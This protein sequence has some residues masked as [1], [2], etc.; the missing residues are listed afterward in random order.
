MSDPG[1]KR[2]D[3]NED[4]ASES[5]PI[6]GIPSTRRDVT[7]IPA[8]LGDIFGDLDAGVEVG[9]E[10]ALNRIL[11]LIA[12]LVEFGIGTMVRGYSNHL[13][14]SF[15]FNA[16]TGDVV[17][18]DVIDDLNAEQVPEQIIVVPTV[19][20]QVEFD[21]N[22]DPNTPSILANS[23]LSSP[24]RVRKIRAR[25]TGGAGGTLKIFAYW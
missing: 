17:E 2:D 7:E 23:S 4:Q 14:S 5:V 15:A 8:G 6:R 3:E 16:S 22:L 24:L 18:Q 10:V 1:R 13:F 19:E 12:T 9:A 25:A 21:N 20:A 11:R